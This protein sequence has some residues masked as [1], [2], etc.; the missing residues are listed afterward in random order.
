[1]ERTVEIEMGEKKTLSVA[2]GGRKIKT[3]DFHGPVLL[4]LQ[5]LD[6]GDFLTH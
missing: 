5:L 1:M 4:Q 2:A 3:V 6:R